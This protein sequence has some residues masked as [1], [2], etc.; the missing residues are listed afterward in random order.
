MTP[1]CQLQDELNCFVLSMNRTSRSCAKDVVKLCEPNVFMF[2]QIGDRHVQY[3]CLV[4]VLSTFV[5]RNTLE[6][7]FVCQHCFPSQEHLA[8]SSSHNSFQD[9]N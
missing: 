6:S 1:K 5:R 7:S 8:S 3:V 9:P 4:D 2:T